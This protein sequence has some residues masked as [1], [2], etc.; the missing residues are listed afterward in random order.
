[1]HSGSKKRR[2]FPYAT[3]TPLFA[4]GDVRRSA[5]GIA[6]SLSIITSRTQSLN[7]NV[8]HS[9][10]KIADFFS[11][12]AIHMFLVANVLKTSPARFDQKEI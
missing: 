11:Q 5:Q 8:S 9:Q 10:S 1:M 12:A 7:D 3:A 4:A 6:L 2:D